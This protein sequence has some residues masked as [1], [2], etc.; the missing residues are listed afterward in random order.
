M[1]A[2]GWLKIQ[3]FGPTVEAFTNMGLPAP[4][5]MVLL[6][7]AAEFGGGLGLIVGLLTPLAA[8]GVFINM[9][10]AVFRVHWPHGLFAKDNGFEFP[11]ILMLT[12]LYFVIRGGGPISLDALFCRGKPKQDVTSNPG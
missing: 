1:A 8:L 4:K 3:A 9:A 6:S 11:G 5:V 2:H 7:I 10:V 12:A